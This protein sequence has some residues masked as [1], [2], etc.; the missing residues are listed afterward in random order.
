MF[1]ILLTKV[2]LLLNRL[3]ILFFSKSYHL[4]IIGSINSFVFF[5]SRLY[6]L[7]KLLI[8]PLVNFLN[9]YQ[10]TFFYKN[11]DLE[12]QMYWVLLNYKNNSIFSF[13]HKLNLSKRGNAHSTLSI[14]HYIICIFPYQFKYV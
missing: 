4:S 14:A 6:I 7:E 3:I 2:F 9:F 12:M 11:L 1:F 13:F 8:R 5:I 10:S